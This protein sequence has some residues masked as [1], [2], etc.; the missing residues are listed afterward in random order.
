M[1]VV[2]PVSVLLVASAVV[3]EIPSDPHTCHELLVVDLAVLGEAIHVA[4]RRGL[5][6]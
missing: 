6:E 2:L 1:V 4:G 3:G 5:V